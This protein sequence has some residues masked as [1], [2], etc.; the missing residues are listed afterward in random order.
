MT[1]PK[2][3]DLLTA[4]QEHPARGLVTVPFHLEVIDG[5]DRGKRFSVDPDDANPILVGQSAACTVRL[6]DRQASRR[7]LSLAPRD[8]RLHLVD[9]GSTNGTAVNDVAV[10]RAWLSGGEVVKLGATALRVD[11]GAPRGAQI[12]ARERF[13]RVLGSS[14]AMTRVFALCEELAKTSGPLLLEGE[15]GTGKEL[16]AEAL[17]DAGPSR[18]GPFLVVDC[19]T[20]PD[21]AGEQIS[22]ALAEAV[23]G[24]VVLHEVADLS[25]PAQALL[26]G[27]LERQSRTTAP[28]RAQTELDVRVIA[29]TSR[30][31][32][33][34]AEEGRFSTK[35]V[36]LLAA[37]RVALPPLR[38]RRGDVRLLAKRFW[39]E[40]AGAS[41]SPTDADLDRLERQSFPGNVR[42]LRNEVARQVAG[43]AGAEPEP[44]SSESVDDVLALEL[45]FSRARQRVLAHF[46]RRYVEHALARHG[47]N[48]S[49]AAETAGLARRYFQLIKAGKRTPP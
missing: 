10:E 14:P 2:E 8:G 7:H 26:L 13:G 19:A 21:P 20:Q 33:R 1:E 30:D 18:A 4:E 43:G 28:A 22:A 31:L 6:T 42:D 23:G 35:L 29:T 27:W 9:L 3:A 46:Q 48:V 44:S 24:S 17:H 5:P 49:R 32:D 47:G 37:R 15:P 16:L 12:S 36:E 34:D 25:G 11:R 41:G 38:D 39:A 40:L 45:P